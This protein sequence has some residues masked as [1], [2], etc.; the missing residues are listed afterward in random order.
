MVSQPAAEGKCQCTHPTTAVGSLLGGQSFWLLSL[1][2]LNTFLC[3]SEP[4]GYW[5]QEEPYNGHVQPV[6][7]EWDKMKSQ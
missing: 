5:S 4:S 1:D 2:Q 6:H 7:F 3:G